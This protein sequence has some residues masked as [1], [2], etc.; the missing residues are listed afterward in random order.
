MLHQ[1]GFTLLETVLALA[2]TSVLLAG[3]APLLTRANHRAREQETGAAL[4]AIKDAIAGTPDG[5][6]GFIAT[7]GRL[8]RS[9]DELLSAD[10]SG[11]AGLGGVP[12]GWVGPYLVSGVPEPLKD[13]WGRS[14]QLETGAPCGA[15]GWRLRSL[16]PDGARSADDDLVLPPQGCFPATGTL[17][18][19]VLRDAG[20]ALSVPAGALTVTLYA[21]LDGHETALPGTVSANS[22]SFSC[23][24]AECQL[25]LG[26]H[27][28]AVQLD[29]GAAF[30]RNVSVTRAVNSAS[31]AFPFPP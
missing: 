4:R 3:L 7:M 26:T 1:R 2:I 10:P 13:G 28:V 9:L 11:R 19:E 30:V 14:F 6:P 27:A 23:G 29:K 17:R 5:A 22:V 18:L 21:A 15:G 16:G 8:P 12:V 24:G 20:A 25:P 31:I